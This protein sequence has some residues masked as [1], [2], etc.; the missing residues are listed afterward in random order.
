ME[1]RMDSEPERSWTSVYDYPG[2]R[3]LFIAYG[4]HWQTIQHSADLST[5]GICEVF[6]GEDGHP[7]F[8]E[9]QLDDAGAPQGLP[10]GFNEELIGSLTL[11][12]I[13]GEVP[14]FM[15][16]TESGV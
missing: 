2:R 8:I 10:P 1:G 15:W 9:A 3:V 13:Q 6:V 12:P 5:A 4:T 16:W 14:R 7:A 11:W